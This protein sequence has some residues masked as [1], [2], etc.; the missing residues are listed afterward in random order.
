MRVVG[1]GMLWGVFVCFGVRAGVVGG[2]WLF[3]K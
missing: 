3:R 1:V 2:G